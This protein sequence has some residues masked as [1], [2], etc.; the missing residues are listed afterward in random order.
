MISTIDPRNPPSFKL[1]GVKTDCAPDEIA[2]AYVLFYNACACQSGFDPKGSN[3]HYTLPPN[4]PDERYL[5]QTPT[6]IPPPPS[7]LIPGITSL[8]RLGA[9]SESVPPVSLDPSLSREFAAISSLILAAGGAPKVTTT[10]TYTSGSQTFTTTETNI[11]WYV[12]GTGGGPTAVPTAFPPPN[13]FE[14][15]LTPVIPAPSVTTMMT[16]LSPSMNA[17]MSSTFSTYIMLTMTDS[18]GMSGTMMSMT[19]GATGA[20]STDN[21]IPVLKRFVENLVG[22]I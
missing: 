5:T 1:K 8:G 9:R 11:A 4:K 21:S 13:P 16:I 7:Y 3:A 14:I 20:A 15:P 2:G 19:S 10:V 17:M 12:T 18:M 22:W 6:F